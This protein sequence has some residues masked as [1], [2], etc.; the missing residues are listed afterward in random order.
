MPLLL[1][2]TMR[3]L[4]QNRSTKKVTVSFIDGVLCFVM[5]NSFDALIAQLSSMKY[6][7]VSE[8]FTIAEF[9]QLRM[10]GLVSLPQRSLLAV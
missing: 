5:K 6:R 9:F 1:T 3:R 2:A 4:L 10:C 8:P 7:N